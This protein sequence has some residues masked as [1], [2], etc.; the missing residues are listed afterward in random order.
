MQDSYVCIEQPSSPKMFKFVSE[1]NV[2]EGL[3]VIEIVSH[4]SQME[5]QLK[6]SSQAEVSVCV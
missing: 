6:N 1:K 2:T 4:K 3:L 5:V